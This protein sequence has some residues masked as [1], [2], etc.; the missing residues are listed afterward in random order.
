MI[1]RKRKVSW[2]RAH[3][4]VIAVDKHEVAGASETERLL[5]DVLNGPTGL[6]VGRRESLVMARECEP[7][8]H[9][10]AEKRVSEMGQHTHKRILQDAHTMSYREYARKWRAKFWNGKEV[11]HRTAKEGPTERVVMYKIR[12]DGTGQVVT[13]SNEVREEV[14]MGLSTKL[15][16]NMSDPLDKQEGPEPQAEG[17]GQGRHYTI[18]WRDLGNRFVSDL[19][20]DVVHYLPEG[21]ATSPDGLD[22][23]I[24]QRM[25]KE[26]HDLLFRMMTRA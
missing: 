13:K 26:F 2:D 5:N 18:P 16:Y 25:P 8:G 22:N 3:G 20:Y 15:P 19:F 24:I 17:P 1:A 7:W 6:G 11:I 14:Y 10:R 12:S 21:E 23:A 4:G 9:G